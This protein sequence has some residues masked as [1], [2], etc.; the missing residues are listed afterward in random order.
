MC[1]ITGFFNTQNAVS[2]TYKA[3]SELKNRGR[4]GS[5]TC[6]LDWVT[7]SYNINTLEMP[8]DNN[9]LGHNLHS[10]VKYVPQPI[11]YSGKIVA[12]C[13]IYN[14]KK[15]SK[16][17]NLDAENDSDFL[18]KFIEYQISNTDFSN[19]VRI[20]DNIEKALSKII[21]VYSFAYM[22]DGYVYVF[23]DII[24]VKPLWYSSSSGFAFAS[25][26][27]ALIKT[28]YLEAYELNP[29]ESI[30][31][32]ITN[33]FFYFYTRNFFDTRPEHKKQLHTIQ[34]EFSNIL[35]DAVSIRVPD[36]PFGILFSGGID[37]TIIAYICKKM[38]KRPGTDFTCYVAGFK[39]ND[40]V[41]SPDV[42]YAKKVADE[43]GLDLKIK[44]ITY[45]EVED[46]LTTVVSLIEDTSV[47]KVGVALTMY[48]ACVAAREDG[49]RVMFS[50]SGAD[51][52]LAG[53]NR[54]WQSE[55]VNYDCYQDILNI[56]QKNTYRD[57]VVSMNNNI[58]LRVPYLDR[59]LID[60]GLKIPAHCKIDN[61]QS[62]NKL[63]LRNVGK[64]LGLHDDFVQRNKKAAQYGSRFD[65]AITKLAKNSGF[66]TKT[67]YLEQF[68]EKS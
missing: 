15:L 26:K 18:I 54:H 62:Q 6:G 30:C 39:G 12:N 23:R 45:Q 1:A 21:G 43:L 28:G 60:Y 67:Q 52:L 13:E 22:L 33:N 51:E 44:Q 36:E 31:Y 63:I 50:G 17:Y 56:Y 48:A 29:R 41:Y 34:K 66:K 3:L 27:K 65:K 42:S 35:E 20:K 47:P 58:E 57:D 64:K 46:Y 37:S 11:A 8:Q 4:D 32:D 25:E 2:S 10:I 7:H 49:I 5:G 16:I 19:P 38:G 53:Y 40:S 24:G 14:W 59:R 61:K 55:D 9:I 68:Y